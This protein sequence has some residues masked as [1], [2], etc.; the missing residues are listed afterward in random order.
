[1]GLIVWVNFEFK[2]TIFSHQI[3]YRTLCP[4]SWHATLHYLQSSGAFKNVPPYTQ[5]SRPHSLF[6]MSP[7]PLALQS[8]LPYSSYPPP[9]PGSQFPISSP[10]PKLVPLNHPPSLPPSRNDD[11]CI[12]VSLYTS[13]AARSAMPVGTQTPKGEKL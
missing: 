6:S 8:Q 10:P 12:C 13:S 1:M 9:S 11:R 4:S 3:S 2:R 5:P 7:S